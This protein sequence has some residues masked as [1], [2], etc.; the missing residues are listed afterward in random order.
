MKKFKAKSILA[1]LTLAFS[2]L[3]PAQIFA[4]SSPSETV[5]TTVTLANTPVNLVLD[6]TNATDTTLPISF[7][8]NGNPS[9]TRYTVE[10][11]SD[12]SNWTVIQDKEID[13]LS[14]T[15]GSLT[16]N[17][18]YFF[19]VS[20]YNQDTPSKTN[21]EFLTGSFYTKP[22]KPAAPTGTV[23]N[24]DITVTWANEP[25]T[26]TKLFDGSNQEI[27]IDPADTSKNLPGQ[28][29]DTKFEYYV[30]HSN[31]TGDSVPSDKLV[32]WTDAVIPANLQVIDRTQ[33]SLK[34]SIDSNGNPA[35]T[36]YQYRLAKTDGTTVDTSNWVAQTT[37]EFTGIAAGEY[38]IFAK[39]KNNPSNPTA[40]ETAEIE[41]TTGTVPVAPT[42][43]VTP[44]ED[45]IK[46]DLTPGSSTDGVEY[47][48]TLMDANDTEVASTG[49]AK[50]GEG[51]AATGLSHTFTNL[52][53]NKKYK[54]QAEARYAN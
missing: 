10:I 7:E 27:Q 49:W 44:T 4:A 32:L 25:G 38:K 47:Q 52:S 39:A 19:R 26:T 53:P 46:V 51:W 8:A 15:A 21:G 31:E 23:N 1:V 33:S 13:V 12:N 45:S 20:S 29:P 36:L 18:Q 28:T 3:S 37:Y 30:I 24:Q 34:V 9:N 6:K 2:I 54:V 14:L 5:V 16:G 43:T 50:S 48:I 40:K 17:K 11:S 22:S 42:A 41:I 35:S